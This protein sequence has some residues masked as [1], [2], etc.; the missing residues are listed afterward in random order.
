MNVSVQR[1][2]GIE[3]YKK[4][5]TQTSIESASPHRLIQMLL[6]GAVEKL[7][8]AKRYMQSGDR[9]LKGSHI[10]WVVSILDGLRMSI[11]KEAG[12]EIGRNLDDLYEYMARRLIEANAQNDLDALDE[13]SVLLF[14]I[15]SAWDAVPE[16]MQA[17]QET[18]S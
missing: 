7:R 6:E 12:G 11:D 1:D 13:V 4:A 8:S 9:A 5:G 16:A 17:Q 10:A 3:Q 2:S 15:K 14:E 18:F